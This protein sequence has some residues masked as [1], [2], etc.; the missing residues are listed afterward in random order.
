MARNIKLTLQYDGTNYGG[1][2]IQTNRPTIQRLLV[3]F[4]NKLQSRS[5]TLHGAGPPDAGVHALNQ[6]ANFQ[7]ERSI[8]FMQLRRAVNANLPHDIRVTA[9][10]EVEQDF[11]ARYCAKQKTYI[12][13]IALGEVVSP[14]EYRY[15]HHYPY[16]L[17]VDSMKTASRALLGT[18]DF[19]AFATASEVESTTRTISELTLDRVGDL[20]ILQVTGDGFLRY[21]V[22]TIVGT[23]IEVGRGR[24]AA[25][26]VKDILVERRR[27]RAGRTAPACG[28]TLLK[29]DY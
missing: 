24:I 1:W 3:D 21:M 27:E 16:K 14:F 12:Y 26:A 5:V 8:S 15:V 10:E 28:L 18:H 25:E 20:L 4:F 2:Q 19:A 29:I 6:T 7:S 9:A 11:H 23:L 17:D 13:K 22:R